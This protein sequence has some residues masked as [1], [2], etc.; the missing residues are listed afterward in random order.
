MTVYKHRDK[1]RYDFWKNGVRQRESGF[2]TKQEA[3]AAEAEAR[4]KLKVMNSDFISLCE[5]RLRD[6]RDRRTVKYFKEN[7][8]LFEKLIL[9]WGNKKKIERKDVDDYLSRVANNSHYVANKELRFIKALFNH[10]VERDMINSNPAEKIKFFPIEKN[11]KYI[12]PEEDIRKVFEF[13]NDEQKL[14]LTAVLCTMARI[15]EINKLKWED[16]H[17]DY[18]ILKTR[19]SKNSDLTERIIPLNE[20]LKEVFDTVPRIAEYVF[21][22]EDGKP[23]FYRSKF[24]KTA[25]RM[26]GV[27]YFGYHALRHYGASRLANS[28]VPI[29]DI[30]ALLGHQ[31]PTTTD[32]YL[33]SIRKSLIGAM[34][35][36]ESPTRVTHKKRVTECNPLI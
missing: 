30:Q 1:W 7:K 4:K 16:I 15:N 14:Y 18:L 5:S 22:H 3:K 31:R 26:A 20:T 6:L 36:L 11:K 25:C 8:S 10:G 34:K 23:Y 13:C 12:P 29:T 33:Q 17:K 2:T 19:K 28:G 21:C 32:I 9:A 35:N 27:R 24:L